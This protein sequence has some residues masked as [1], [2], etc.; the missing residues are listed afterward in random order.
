M[1][2]KPTKKGL[3]RGEFVDRYGQTCSIQESSLAGEDC[4]W[5]GV[6][7]DREGREVL[8]GRMHLTRD[9]A[10]QLIPVLRHFVREGTLGMDEP[11]E[12]FHIGAW[13]AGVGKDNRGV[14]GRVIAMQRGEYMTVQDQHRPGD[15]GQII[16]MWEV[17]DLIWVP[18]DVPDHIPTRYER[19][20][21]ED[22]EFPDE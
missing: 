12:K 13:V 9:M 14:E 10:R 21:E 3:L 7:V 4:A 8:N 6:E 19:L 15:A 5:L 20:R 1:E 17:A 2:F 11:R 22:D 16:C 18:I